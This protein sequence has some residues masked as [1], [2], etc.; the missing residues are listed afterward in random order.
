MQ[1][2]FGAP[3]LKTE[4]SE[5]SF[6]GYSVD[7]TNSVH[8]SY[9]QSELMFPRLSILNDD[10]AYDPKKTSHAMDEFLNFNHSSEE[11]SGKVDDNSHENLDFKM[12]DD[13]FLNMEAMLSDNY[14]KIDLNG[15]SVDKPVDVVVGL[16]D[17][18]VMRNC[19][20]ADKMENEKNDILSENHFENDFI[21]SDNDFLTNSNLLTGKHM[22]TE[23][24]TFDENSSLIGDQVFNLDFS[25]SQ[26][27][28]NRSFPNFKAVGGR[29]PEN[30]INDYNFVNSPNLNLN[31]EDSSYCL[32]EDRDKNYSTFELGSKSL[33]GVKTS[34]EINYEEDGAGLSDLDLNLNKNDEFNKSDG[35]Y[36]KFIE[37]EI[38]NLFPEGL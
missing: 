17:H 26:M 3:D 16:P 2:F 10:L 24:R 1:E 9:K 25:N 29:N 4:A 20:M 35:R 14:P 11:K 22:D 6:T 8:S 28:I 38:I 33:E 21:L 15:I 30:G 13:S 5:L 34:S 27:Y 12:S 19:N 7:D 23:S 37:L 18:F 31:Y 32:M 36:F